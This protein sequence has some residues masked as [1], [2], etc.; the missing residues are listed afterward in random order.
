MD[1][2]ALSWDTAKRMPG[3]EAT[4]AAQRNFVIARV[5]CPECSKA[6]GFATRDREFGRRIIESHLPAPL[7]RDGVAYLGV[8]ATADDD[9]RPSLENKKG[10][11]A[12]WVERREFYLDATWREP[13][14]PMSQV[15]FRCARHGYLALSIIELTEAFNRHVT[16]QR[17][18]RLSAIPDPSS[19]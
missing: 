11:V 3:D 16:G 19:D 10:H 7:T 2:D 9:F 6:V 14:D 5:V 1:V 17:P 13:I 4:K 8:Q 12:P 15:P 18:V